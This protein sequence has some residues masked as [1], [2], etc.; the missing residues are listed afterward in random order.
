MNKFRMSA[1]QHKDNIAAA[2]QASVPAG[3]ALVPLR[4]TPAMN[5]VLDDE[6]WQW[7]DLLAV[8]GAIAEDQYDEIAATPSP[9]AAPAE[10][11]ATTATDAWNKVREE[12]RAISGGKGTGDLLVAVDAFGVACAEPLS[13]PERQAQAG[14][15]PNRRSDLRYVL[16]TLE[17]EAALPAGVSEKQVRVD[18]PASGHDAQSALSEIG[19]SDGRPTLPALQ[20][21]SMWC[22]SLDKGIELC[23]RH[24]HKGDAE[25]LREMKAALADQVTDSGEVHIVPSVRDAE[26]SS[27]RDGQKLYLATHS[28][29]IDKVDAERW[30]MV[31]RADGGLTHRLHN[32]RPDNRRAVIDAAI[33]ATG[34]KA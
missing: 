11:Q 19:I 18:S 30:R 23:A 22:A 33:A 4:L 17:N 32:S 21:G 34:S 16:A 12:A 25:T 8:A 24:G 3:F 7:E 27:L 20:G 10:P 31:E 28:Q 15:H 2:R 14:V 26:S 29:V 9:A 5:R 1:G 13:R 6:G